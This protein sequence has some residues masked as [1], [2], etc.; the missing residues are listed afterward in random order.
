MLLHIRIVSIAATE[1]QPMA[2]ICALFGF[3]GNKSKML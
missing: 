2:K 1:L 3:K